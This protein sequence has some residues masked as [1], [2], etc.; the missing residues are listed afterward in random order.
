MSKPLEMRS[1]GRRG[2]SWDWKEVAL[3]WNLV[4]EF[5]KHFTTSRPGR[6]EKN[7]W[8]VDRTEFDVGVT[9][10][11]VASLVLSCSRLI[12]CYQ[13]TG[14]TSSSQTN[15]QF[16]FS[17]RFSIFLLLLPN[18]CCFPLFTLVQCIPFLPCAVSAHRCERE[19]F[20]EKRASCLQQWEGKWEE[21]STWWFEEKG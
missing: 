3:V 8:T 14:V 21:K 13:N 10:I 6:R 11:V 5:I 19:V 4:G 2:K 1:R 12:G 9:Q 18:L 15:G 7:W 17:H 16:H 20:Y